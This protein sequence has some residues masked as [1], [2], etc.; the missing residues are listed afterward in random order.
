MSIVSPLRAPG[1]DI[2]HVVDKIDA[3]ELAHT[4]PQPLTVFHSFLP[5]VPNA[6]HNILWS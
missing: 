3:Q 4:H 1:A 2:G 6:I 5:V